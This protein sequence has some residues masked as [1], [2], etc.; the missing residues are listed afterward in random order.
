MVSCVKND[1]EQ[2][3]GTQKMKRNE[4]RSRREH[5]FPR[6]FPLSAQQY[7]EAHSAVDQPISFLLTHG[8]LVAFSLYAQA[9]SLPEIQKQD[10]NESCYS[11]LLFCLYS[12][13]CQEKVRIKNREGERRDGDRL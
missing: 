4:K 3:A 13:I 12:Y 9:V 5:L 10:K 6:A 8:P 1:H 7:W 11:F 2:G